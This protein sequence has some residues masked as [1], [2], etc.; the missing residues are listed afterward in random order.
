MSF[1]DELGLRAAEQLEASVGPYVALASYKRLLA[2]PPEI[3]DK[4]TL[5]A[6]RCAVAL[7]DEGE[8][9]AL[10]KTWAGVSKSIE[11]ATPLAIA[12]LHAGRSGAARALAAAELE[13]APTAIAAYVCARAVEADGDGPRDRAAVAE[14]FSEVL[15]RARLE[16]DETVLARAAA[17]FVACVFAGLDLDP[18]AVLDRA[19]VT[20]AAEIATLD[21]TP[22]PETLA[23]LR[24]RLLSTNRFHRAA[25]LSSL[26]ELAR[27]ERGPLRAAAIQLAARHFDALLT[28]L[29]AVE[30]DRIGATMKHWPDEAERQ[31][32]LARLAALVRVVA[33]AKA[34]EAERAARLDQALTNL[35][36][37]D[38]GAAQGLVAARALLA[39]AR[40][41]GT[42]E[43]TGASDSATLGWLG[44]EAISAIHGGSPVLAATALERAAPLL[45]PDAPP[46]PSL[47]SALLAALATG[48][49]PASA[50]AAAVADRALGRTTGVPHYP[51]LLLADALSAAGAPEVAAKALVEAARWNEGGAGSRLAGVKRAAAYDALAKDDR[52]RARVLLGEAR[53]LFGVA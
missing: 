25:A 29:D 49:G 7:G 53:A 13:R 8:L 26:E 14:R 32:A 23:V 36:E 44:L 17:R 4:A 2:G 47:W 40:G 37:R 45:G 28:R 20:H 50:A 24:G 48:R 46:P 35:A 33:A 43:P 41:A 34:P 18:S 51:M 21:R 10:T 12:L 22:P 9:A 42:T 3:R 11:P 27:R 38:A 6:L 39:G 5:G 31:R 1:F 19:R 52:E 16:G 30:I 15:E